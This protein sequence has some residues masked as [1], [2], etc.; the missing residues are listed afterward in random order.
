MKTR[1]TVGLSL[2]IALLGV[3]TYSSRAADFASGRHWALVSFMEPVMVKNQFIMGSVLIVHDDAKMARGEPC[4]TFYRFEPGKGQQE[5]L[6]SFHCR[7]IH[8]T[9]AAETV[10]TVVSGPDSCKRLIEYQIAGDDEA[11]G[12]PSK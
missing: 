11:H 10:L 4:T 9:A 6:V 2:L 7:P 1:I 8:R 3:G 5:E 12:I